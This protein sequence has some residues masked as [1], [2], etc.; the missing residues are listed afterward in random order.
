MIYL[1]RFLLKLQ[2]AV[3][4]HGAWSLHIATVHPTCKVSFLHLFFFD[5]FICVNVMGLNGHDVN[6][7]GF[8]V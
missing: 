5:K 6:N 8:R 2:G 3:S 1:Q 7:K 4:H